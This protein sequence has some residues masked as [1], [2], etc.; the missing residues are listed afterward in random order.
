MPNALSQKTLTRNALSLY[1][2]QFCRK[3]LPFVCVPYLARILGPAG[4]GRVAFAVAFGEILVMLIEFGFN[5]SATREV[6]RHRDSREQCRAISAGVLGAQAVLSLAAI[7]CALIVMP[8]VPG[9]RDYPRLFAGALFYG[10][11]QGIAPV[12]FFQGLERMGTAA[13]LEVSGKLLGVGCVFAVAHVPGDDWKVVLVQALPSAISAVVGIALIQR[14]VGLEVPT[15]ASVRAALKRGWPLFLFRSGVGLYGLANAF[16]LGLFA[17]AAQVGYYAS[18]EKVSKAAYGLLSPMREAIYPRLSNLMRH[19]PSDARRLA[20]MGSV[21]ATGAGLLLSVVLCVMA[22]FIIRILMGPGFEPAVGVLRILSALPLIIAVTES[23]GLQWLL[24]QGRDM[25]VTKI[26]FGGGF[27]NLALSFVLAPRFGHI[28]MAW[29]VVTAET[30]VAVRMAMAAFE[31]ARVQEK[32]LA[33]ARGSEIQAGGSE[34][35]VGRSGIC[36][37]AAG[38]AV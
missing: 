27:L 30:F 13:V 1:G 11:A 20:R 2:V 22:P 14:T 3:L 18:S 19:S 23:V 24:P 12:W 9:L 29:A 7:A 31:A 38:E 37:T 4:W 15:L 35:G 26:I 5:L 16:V 28:G 8:W 6:A 33:D 10:I 36:P 21:I 17:P 25:S 32:P 34:I